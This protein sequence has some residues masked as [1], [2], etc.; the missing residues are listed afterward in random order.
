MND[1]TNYIRHT[2]HKYIMQKNQK[3]NLNSAVEYP[4]CVCVYVFLAFYYV[5]GGFF[6]CRK[7]KIKFNPKKSRSNQKV[8]KSDLSKATVYY[9]L[10]F[11]FF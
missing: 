10:R 8:K 1:V 7:N 5:N 4:M 3:N 6:S 9:R 2:Q 11:K